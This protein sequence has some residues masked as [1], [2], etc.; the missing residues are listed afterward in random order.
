[1]LC[2]S[3]VRRP[4]ANAALSASTAR[5]RSASE[6]RVLPEPAAGAPC[7]GSTVIVSCLLQ[8]ETA[9][10]GG[11]FGGRCESPGSGPDPRQHD[12][13]YR[14]RK[15]NQTGGGD[16]AGKTSQCHQCAQHGEAGPPGQP[17]ARSTRRLADLASSVRMVYVPHFVRYAVDPLFLTEVADGFG[18]LAA[19][20][21]PSTRRGLHRIPVQEAS[22]QRFSIFGAAPGEATAL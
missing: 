16:A 15:Q 4:S 19:G 9:H 13:Q 21:V 20:E 12:N 11:W 10:G 7:P 6:A 18:Q 3:L 2:S 22:F 14:D 5:S 8:A 17:F 1:M